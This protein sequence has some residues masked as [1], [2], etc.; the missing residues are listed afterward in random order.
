MNQFKQ[1][2]VDRSKELAELDNRIA[3][4]SRNKPSLVSS[5]VQIADNS[6]ENE[7]KALKKLE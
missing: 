4:F 5:P 3:F 2:E 1:Q 7:E 6:L